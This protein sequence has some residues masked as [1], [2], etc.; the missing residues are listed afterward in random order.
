[1][2]TRAQIRMLPDERRVHMQDGPIDLIVEAFGAA[3]EVE[4]AYRAAASRFVTVLDELCGELGF[5]R[6]AIPR[7][8]NRETWGTRRP[9]RDLGCS[10]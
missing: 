7:F 10:G 6:Q 2:N 1:M 9:A 4:R 5:L 3:A 8:E